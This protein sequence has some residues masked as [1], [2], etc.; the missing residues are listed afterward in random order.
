MMTQ[1]LFSVAEEAASSQTP[2]LWHEAP[3][4]LGDSTTLPSQRPSLV[5]DLAVVELDYV[6]LHTMC[7]IT[8]A[9][10]H[11]GHPSVVETNTL[12]K[13]CS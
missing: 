11:H 13:N 2:N 4:G 1:T 3:N 10:T 12:R 7:S 9:T 8:T 6:Q 5:Q